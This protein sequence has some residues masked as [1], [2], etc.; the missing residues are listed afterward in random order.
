[1]TRYYPTK[2][3]QL[4]GYLKEQI[5]DLV[6]SCPD[7]DLKSE[8]YDQLWYDY[9]ELRKHLTA[10]DLGII[11]LHRYV[12]DVDG[13]DPDI[14]RCSKRLRTRITRQKGENER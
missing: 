4:L 9:D 12:K 10:L 5:Q 6:A 8:V 2:T 14:Y 1:M 7:S 13:V 11:T 3:R